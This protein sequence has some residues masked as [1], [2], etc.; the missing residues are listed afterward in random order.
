[1]IGCAMLCYETPKEH[2]LRVPN[3]KNVKDAVIGY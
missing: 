3:K 2:H 1:M